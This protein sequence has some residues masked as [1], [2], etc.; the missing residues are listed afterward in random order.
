VPSKSNSGALQA[1]LHQLVADAPAAGGGVHPEG[2]QAGPAVRPAEPLVGGVLV[3]GHR[4]HDPAVA[5]GHQQPAGAG[6]VVQVEQVL[7][8]G[9]EHP[10][11]HHRV[12]LLVGGAQDVTDR[13]VVG[14]RG[15]ADGGGDAGEAALGHDGTHSWLA[16]PR[17]T[18]PTVGA[19]GAGR[20]GS[21]YLSAR[22]GGA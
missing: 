5:L 9:P 7:Q 18:S 12:V 11:R 4:A 2:A 10:G 8:V 19:G 13:R 3:E 1:C 6:A 15:V 22:G 21:R 14:G 20:I 16:E 17:F